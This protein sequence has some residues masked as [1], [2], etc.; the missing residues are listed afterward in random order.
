MSRSK[1]PNGI[2]EAWAL[3]GSALVYETVTANEMKSIGAFVIIG[4]STRKF[5]IHHYDDGMPMSGPWKLLENWPIGTQGA[6]DNWEPIED[7]STFRDARTKARELARQSAIKGPV[8]QD[9]NEDCIVRYGSDGN[10][11]F[12]AILTNKHPR[13][14]QIFEHEGALR[15]WRMSVTLPYL[16][17]KDEMRA[18]A[19]LRGEIAA[20]GET[21]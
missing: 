8:A 16:N 9:R 17:S 21:L 2:F 7:F 4:S 12:V 3:P 14:W 13:D 19:Y 6:V 20:N 10:G 15:A 1:K 18:L 11:L 5:R